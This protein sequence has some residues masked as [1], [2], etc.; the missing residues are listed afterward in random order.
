[1]SCSFPQESKLIIYKRASNLK[2][3]RWLEKKNAESAAKTHISTTGESTQKHGIGDTEENG[4][5]LLLTATNFGSRNYLKQSFRSPNSR[6]TE[7]KRVQSEGGFSLTARIVTNK[8]SGFFDKT[9]SFA[10]TSSGIG[11]NA[12]STTEKHQ[13]NLRSGKTSSS[14]RCFDLVSSRL[15][16]QNS[17]NVKYRSTG[18]SLTP[19]SDKHLLN[20]NKKRGRG[21]VKCIDFSTPLSEIMQSCQRVRDTRP[22]RKQLLKQLEAD[23]GCES[24]T[25]GKSLQSVEEEL[26]QIHKDTS[27]EQ[28]KQF[29]VLRLT[30]LFHQKVSRLVVGMIKDKKRVREMLEDVS[31]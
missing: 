7:H 23:L 13:N 11:R 19:T 2:L 20:T 14:Q 4:G 18:S 27:Q 12:D 31:S 15:N 29:R 10:Q 17:T 6:A 1:M 21:S 26:T 16:Q 25:L 28:D 5:N 3:T 30:N 9:K 8:S 24:A 22:E